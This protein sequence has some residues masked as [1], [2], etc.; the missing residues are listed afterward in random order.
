MIELLIQQIHQLPPESQKLLQIAACL[1]S[2]F[3][4]T[5]L[6]I[7]AGKNMTDCAT[8]LWPA[9]DAGLILQEGGDWYLGVVGATNLNTINLKQSS[10]SLPPRCRFLHDK[11]LQAAYNCIEVSTLEQ[12]HLAIGRRLFDHYTDENHTRYLFGL[13][14]HLNKG[15]KLIISSDERLTLA[16]LNEQAAQKAKQSGAWED[17]A[18]YAATGQG[19]LPQNS[20]KTHYTLN[21]SLHSVSAECTALEGDH[22]KAL[23]LYQALMLQAQSER[24]K[25][26]LCLQQVIL[27]LGQAKWDDALVVGQEGLRYCGLHLPSGDQDVSEG[28]PVLANQLA[29]LMEKAPT[30]SIIHLPEMQDP[31]I[32]IAMMLISNIG[33]VFLLEVKSIV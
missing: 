20:W 25:A 26:Q 10:E 22:E 1:G 23:M 7:A 27:F 3:D 24:E 15:Q 6:S 33:M 8:H 12:N 32:R 19:L 30:K 21:Y 5:R 17:A 31:L 2:H 14:K 11:V 13:I 29:I 28:L 9:L 18:R 16:T 4:L